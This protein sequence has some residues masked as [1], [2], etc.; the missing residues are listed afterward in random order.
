MWDVLGVW[1]LGDL[2][3][4]IFLFLDVLLCTNSILLLCVI[5]CVSLQMHYNFCLLKKL[6]IKKQTKGALFRH[7]QSA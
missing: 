3:C 4:S 5:S 2:V 7:L 1:T 6:K